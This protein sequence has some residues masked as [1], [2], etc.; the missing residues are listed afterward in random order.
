[1]AFS[2]KI[3]RGTIGI[4]ISVAMCFVLFIGITANRLSSYSYT[5]E[6]NV[7]AFCRFTNVKACVHSCIYIP[8][9]SCSIGSYQSQDMSG[10]GAAAGLCLLL[11][12]VGFIVL[13]IAI[14][15]IVLPQVSQF[16]KVAIISKWLIFSASICAL[17]AA[18]IWLMGAG[19]CL[20]GA[21]SVSWTPALDFIVFI[22]LIVAFILIHVHFGENQPALSETVDYQQL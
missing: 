8:V 12:L 7:S 20:D 2:L 1:M 19:D 13:C 6:C 16:N 9:N 10:A 3:N 4:I 5:L 14:L 18:L 22:G 15:S 11:N 17:S 21:A